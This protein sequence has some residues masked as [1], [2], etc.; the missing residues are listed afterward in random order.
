M[1]DRK[2]NEFKEE[3]RTV[4]QHLRQLQEPFVM[5]L[6][7]EFNAGKST[8]YNAMVHKDV[9]ARGSTPTT[10]T[11]T[12]LCD[13][14]TADA[15]SWLTVDGTKTN[16]HVDVR[17]VSTDAMSAL[18]GMHVVDTPGTNAMD[19]LH[20]KL[21]LQAMDRAEIGVFI[22]SSTQPMSSSGAA[23]LSRMKPFRKHI[24]VVCNDK[25]P[26][27]DPEHDENL[28]HALRRTQKQAARALGLDPVG[29]FPVAALPV[30]RARD[31]AVGGPVAT[32]AQLRDMRK[33]EQRLGQML[34]AP[35]RAVHKMAAAVSAGMVLADKTAEHFARQSEKL[36]EDMKVVHA[37]RDKI[38]T[39]EGLMGHK[40]K[41]SKGEFTRILE[42]HRQKAK[43]FVREKIV[44]S[45]MQYLAKNTTSD[46]L[47]AAVTASLDAQLKECAKKVGTSVGKDAIKFYTT[48]IAWMEGEFRN[49]CH[50]CNDV[51]NHAGEELP[52]KNDKLVLQLLDGVGSVLHD[53]AKLVQDGWMA[54]AASNS[55]WALAAASASVKYGTVATAAT[56]ACA[57]VLTSSF[58]AVPG[59]AK[60]TAVGAA[61][62]KPVLAAAGALGVGGWLSALLVVGGGYGCVLW[63]YRNSI[64]GSIDD[65]FNELATR[66]PVLMQNLLKQHH[67][68]TAEAVDEWLAWYSNEVEHLERSHTEA[69]ARF[70][71]KRDK[72][73]KLRNR[74]H[75]YSRRSQPQWQTAHDN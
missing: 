32:A 68:T 11:V 60:V 7:G 72:L 15:P 1:L 63:R 51:S 59:L 33:F 71:A 3:C 27:D 70:E 16:D 56:C 50:R 12:L 36:Q 22:T 45:N 47:E 14:D 18:S 43:A 4:N 20:E 62:G 55:S 61:V 53:H 74:I 41:A 34:S 57:K 29:V 24:L 17:I 73:M 46:D 13:K 25:T 26:A 67:S 64:L 21:A 23:L 8:F 19:E 40:M 58:I 38:R 39:F 52:F 9:Q 35:Q 49:N 30:L 75:E 42:D 2:G 37:A 6:F 65:S 5:V 10:K 69:K 28:A 44:W 66:I 31:K 54:M 48:T